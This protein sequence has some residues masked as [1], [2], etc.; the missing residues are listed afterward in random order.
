MSRRHARRTGKALPA[1][2]QGLNNEL[3]AATTKGRNRRDE[4]DYKSSG[5]GL[6]FIGPALAPTFGPVMRFVFGTWHAGLVT[7]RQVAGVAGRKS[8]P[9]VTVDP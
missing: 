3:S 2:A 4:Y 1:W 7:A 5:T 6:Y 9:R 8:Q